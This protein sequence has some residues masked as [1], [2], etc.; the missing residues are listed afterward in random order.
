MK[1]A[2]KNIEANPYRG[3]KQYPIDKT[4]VESLKDSIRSTSFWD[5]ILVRPHPTKK[6][7]YQLA[8]GH[9]RLVAIKELNIKEIDVPIRKLDDAMMVKIMA[10]EN[11]EW[12]H[13]P[14]VIIQTVDSVRTFL[15]RKIAK[16]KTLKEFR[17]TNVSSS[18]LHNLFNNEGNFQQSKKYG[19]GQ[20]N[21]IKF[22][23]K[24]WKNKISS[25]LS[26]LKDKN[27]DQTT[28]SQFKDLYNAGQF[29]KTVIEQNIPKTEQKKLAKETAKIVDE[30]KIGGRDLPKIVEALIDDKLDPKII[31][32]MEDMTAVSEF[33][34]AVNLANIPKA[35]QQKIAKKMIENEVE[36]TAILMNVLEQVRPKDKPEDPELVKVRKLIE[37][38]GKDA[39]RLNSK[40][41]TLDMYLNELSITD[42]RGLTTSVA[43]DSLENLYYSITAIIRRKE[44]KT[45]KQLMQVNI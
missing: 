22:L 36:P 15:D 17:A 2:V 33:R 27:F 10:E 29:Q 45:Q 19:V 35:K 9:H 7:K 1:I 41:N 20:P 24:K 40:I 43:G 26:I 32:I 6:D 37:D 21:I 38:I 34:K 3:I 4:K 8:Y 14:Q 23:S 28:A 5:N 44:G 39:D 25:S 42:V 30:K 11:F 12:S 16:C 31:D 13:S 18:L